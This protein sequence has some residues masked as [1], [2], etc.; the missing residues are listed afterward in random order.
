MTAAGL[1]SG[2]PLPAAAR[3]RPLE[4]GAAAWLAV[5]PCAL[6]TLLAIVL[7]GPPLGHAFFARGTERFWPKTPVAPEPVEHARFLLALAGAAGGDAAVVA[8]AR[9]APRLRPDLVRRLALAGQLGA[10]AFVALALLGQNGV[11]FRGYVPP[12]TL[13]HIFKPATLAAAALFALALAALL[14][15]RPLVEALAHAARDTRARRLASATI[16]VLLALVWLT[17]AFNTE[18]SIALAEA[19]ELIPWDLSETF[20][21]LDGRTP[22]VD[23]HS[24]Y[25]QLLPYLFAGA[26]RLVGTTV[27]GWTTTMIACSAAALLA[28]YAVLRRVAGSALLALALFVPFLAGSAFLIRGRLSPLEV[29]SVWPMRYGPPYALAWLTARQLDGARPRR[30]P[31][32]LAAAGLVAVNNLEF[33]LP[34]FGGTL[35]A[36]VC[37]DPPRTR[38]AAR[39]L[40]RD[41]GAG[42]L[43]AVALV[44]AVSLAHG[45]ALPRPALLLEFPRIYGVGGWVLEP[46]PPVGFQLAMYA[47]FVA[48]MVLATVRALRGDRGRA[49]TGML[50]WSGIFGLGAA[51]YYVGRSDTLNLTSLFSAWCLAL[52]LLSL[53]AI[54]GLA[55]APRRPTLPELAVLFGLGLAACAVFQM[56]RPWNELHRVRRETAEVY[57]QLE[58][59]EL[60][61]RTT[62]RG[63]RVAILTALGDRV[64]FDA[65]VVD[66]APYASMAAMPTRE[67]LDATLA[68]MRSAGA[69]QL[70]VDTA[71]SFPAQLH[72][73]AAAGYRQVAAAGTY[74]MFVRRR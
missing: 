6:V 8:L 46:M 44:C 21:V 38:A 70:Y 10:V 17:A 42:L 41:A 57:K 47:T 55:G 32:L 12:S 29:F 3:P 18:R 23:F 36:L 34:A 14:R 53:V 67:Q 28:V 74:V 35:A 37:A 58:A 2:D 39:R 26:T 20:A 71:Q 62:R 45:G 4:A 24:Q 33:G 27:E 61:E 72:A 13:E 64:A 7:L 60:V 52:V 16:A 63:Q 54:R 19:S 1:R 65:R 69:T 59:V 30:R 73:L 25:A 15:R 5:L 43:A 49:L 11:F 66:V 9:R 22:L 56:P 50:A 68:A 40:L 48:A 51:S 31:L